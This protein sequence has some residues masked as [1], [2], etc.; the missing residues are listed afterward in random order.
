MQTTYACAVDDPVDALHSIVKDTRGDEVVDEDEFELARGLGACLQHGVR[1]GLGTSDGSHFDAP[2][3]QSVDDM[4][5]QETSCSCD[6]DVSRQ[7]QYQYSQP[8]EIGRVTHEGDMMEESCI[9]K[10]VSGVYVRTI[11]QS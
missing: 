7:R 11:F 6:E 4:S 1:L 10:M 8:Q 5:T 9:S 3:Q 2:F